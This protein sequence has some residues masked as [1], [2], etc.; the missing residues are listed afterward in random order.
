MMTFKKTVVT[1]VVVAAMT[2]L[3]GCQS[4]PELRQ[5]SVIEQL[6]SVSMLRQDNIAGAYEVA[7]ATGVDSVFVAAVPAFEPKSGG[8]VHRLDPRSLQ[9]VQ[10]IQLP[11]RA[12]A[13]GYNP[14]SS[15]LY[16]GNTLDG[17]LTVIDAKNG[18]VKGMIQ[19]GERVENEKGQIS[20]PH[21][22]KVVVDPLRNQIFVTSPDTEGLVW[23]VDGKTNSVRHTIAT[24]GPWPAG[25][26]F[27]RA[28]NRLY[29]GQGGLNEVVVINPDNGEIITKFSTGDTTSTNP[30]ES[31]HFFVNLTIDEAGQRLFAADAN[32]G[33]VYVFDLNTGNVAQ[34]IAVGEGLLDVA[35]SEQRNEILATNRGVSRGSPAGTGSLTVIDAEN[36]SVKRRVDLPVH[37]N[38]VAVSA[39]G[40]TAYVTVKAP[41]GNDH[42]AWRKDAQD[43]IV[44]IDLQ[45]G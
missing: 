34:T 37:P 2:V 28:N 11:R 9:V 43:S 4:V 7:V 26:A 14:T 8:M 17:S 24:D 41:H 23:I 36:Y 29:V 21:T 3:A 38:S 42:P 44:R 6:S 1:T 22:R 30:K 33:S 25:A 32:T 39:N 40:Q 18:E 16:V 20:A 12:F 19:L 5:Q 10:S 45:G 27:D 13:L 15:T 35:Y 31:K